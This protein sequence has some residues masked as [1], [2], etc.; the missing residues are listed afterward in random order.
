[1]DARHVIRRLK[2]PVTLLILV[3]FVFLAGRW[4]LD[5]ARDPIPPRPTEPCVVKEVGPVLKPEHVY[6]MVYNG[7][8]RDG[9]AK[10]LGSILSADG[11]KVYKRVNADR[12][13]YP[14]SFVRGHSED[15]PEVVLVRQAFEGIAFEADGRVDRSVDVVIG[16]QAPTPHPNPEFGVPLPDGK[17]CLPA[18]R[19]VDLEG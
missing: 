17:A 18:L 2:T 14:T 10:R 11:F 16:A 9:V 6:V 7:S 13:D 8:Q 4:G 15:A 3:L 5:A 1:M 19:I 12:D